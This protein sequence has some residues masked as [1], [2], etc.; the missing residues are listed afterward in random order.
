MKPSQR[1]QYAE[2]IDRVVARIEA[3]VTD[4]RA[5]SLTELA[6]AAALSEFHFHR[7]F[8]LMTGETVGE[9]VRRVRLARTLPDLASKAAVTHAA[10]ASGYATPQGFARAL[11]RQAGITA[12]AARASG[13]ELD[14]LAAKLRTPRAVA[15]DVAPPLALE[16]V[17]VDPFRLLAIRNLGD[18]AELNASY[19]RLFDLVLAQ[20]P[21]EVLNGIYGVPH[22]DPLSTPP[23][24][25]R[26][27]CAL[28]VGDAGLAEGELAE[29][30]LGGGS[31]A[32]LRHFGDYDRVHVAVDR[33]YAGVIGILDRAIADTPLFIHYLDDPEEV[34]EAE[35][36]SDIYVPLAQP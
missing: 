30:S 35:L 29:L 27:D 10:G 21:P 8:R 26:C 24:A 17:S 28:A 5:P 13:G 14:A 6:Q 23:E 16:V 20:V 18:Y 19:A 7:I 11:Q 22:D 34:P 15:G 9:A 4:E 1:Q 3:G 2:R 32:Q 12:T 25:C 31:Y 33:A 36:R